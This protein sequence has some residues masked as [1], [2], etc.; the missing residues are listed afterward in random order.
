MSVIAKRAGPSADA[1][2]VAKAARQAYDDL[3]GVLVPLIGQVGIEALT[4]RA[5]HLAQIDYQSDNGV[6]AEKLASGQIRHWLE[7]QDPATASDA[8][9]TMLSALG[10]LLVTFIGE[11]LTMRLLRKAW[12]DGFPDAAQENAG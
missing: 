5:M 4:T 10:G 1:A 3:T 9:A 12:G 7:R 11:P 6:E 8:A 2:A